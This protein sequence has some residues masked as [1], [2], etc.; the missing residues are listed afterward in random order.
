MTIPGETG[1]FKNRLW[2]I[3]V[4]QQCHLPTTNFSL[5]GESF[6][7]GVETERSDARSTRRVGLAVEAKRSGG[8]RNRFSAL[9]YTNL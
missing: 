9:R 6:D 8:W 7:S 2:N 5:R 1:R 4:L 3:S